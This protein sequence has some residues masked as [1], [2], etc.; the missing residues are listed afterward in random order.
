MSET[1]KGSGVVSPDLTGTSAPAWEPVDGCKHRSADQGDNEGKETASRTCTGCVAIDVAF[2]VTLR[3]LRRLQTG[4]VTR[5]VAGTV[6]LVV[7]FNTCSK[8]LLRNVH[9][10]AFSMKRTGQGI[11]VMSTRPPSLNSP[12]NRTEP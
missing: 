6:S 2:I 7:K 5:C 8:S 11:L 9:H 10:N 1:Q 4:C 3:L 12:R